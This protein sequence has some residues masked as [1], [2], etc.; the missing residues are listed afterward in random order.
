MFITISIF[1]RGMLFWC[2]HGEREKSEKLNAIYE[3]YDCS[4]ALYQLKEKN[5][6]VTI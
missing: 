5:A 6:F 1:I 2:F 4:P 3:V